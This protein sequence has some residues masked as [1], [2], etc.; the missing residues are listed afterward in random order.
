[1]VEV[2]GN[3]NR[4]RDMKNDT[5]KKSLIMDSITSRERHL[6][7]EVLY[8]AKFLYHPCHPSSL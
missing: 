7:A 4:D 5:R 6:S 8:S 3:M 2:D 1:M